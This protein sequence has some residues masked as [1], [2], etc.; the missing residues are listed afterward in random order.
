MDRLQARRVAMTA[1]IAI[2]NKNAV[3]LGADSAVISSLP[4]TPLGGS[5]I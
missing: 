4:R 5:E 3:T 2:S 1:E